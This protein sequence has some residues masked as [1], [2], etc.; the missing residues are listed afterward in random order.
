MSYLRITPLLVTNKYLDLITNEEKTLGFGEYL[1]SKGFNDGW[2]VLSKHEVERP[3]DC[4]AE[5]IKCVETKDG[6]S[7]SFETL[8]QAKAWIRSVGGKHVKHYNSSY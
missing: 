3:N 7:V 5:I 1:I 8:A 4:P 2:S 6:D